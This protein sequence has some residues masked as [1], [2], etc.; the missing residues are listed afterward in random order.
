MANCIASP[1]TSLP[2]VQDVAAMAGVELPS[3][4]GRI[5]DDEK[6]ADEKEEKHEDV[7]K[8]RAK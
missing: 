3:Y 1:V 2:P 5:K 4:L 8:P 7:K 6:K